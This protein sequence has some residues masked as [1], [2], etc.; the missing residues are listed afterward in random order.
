MHD[1]IFEP[2]LVRCPGLLILAQMPGSD[3]A[4]RKISKNIPSDF[5]AKAVN[6]CVRGFKFCSLRIC[7]QIAPA[8]TIESVL[9]SLGDCISWRA[10]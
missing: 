3:G 6:S 8:S 2:Q 5:N 7:C 9:N 4:E 1:S 10:R